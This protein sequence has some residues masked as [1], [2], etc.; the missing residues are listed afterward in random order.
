MLYHVKC[1]M[2]SLLSWESILNNC[3]HNIDLN[4]INKQSI[5]SKFSIL[6]VALWHHLVTENIGSDNGLLPDGTKPLPE[7]MLTDHQWSPVSF[8]LGQFHKRCLKHQSQ[9]ICLKMTCLKFHSNFPGA[10]VTIPTIVP[11][12]GVLKAVTLTASNNPC[13]DKAVPV[14]TVSFQPENV[15]LTGKQSCLVLKHTL[16]Y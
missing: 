2:H 5:S 16:Y 4:V 15:S 8:I 12:L 9:K 13:D 14:K 7:P 3:T 11:S 10:N 1:W 6:F